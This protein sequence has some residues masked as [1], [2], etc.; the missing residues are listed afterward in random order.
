MKRVMKTALAAAMLLMAGTAS[1]QYKF[2][3][4]MMDH[5]GMMSNDMYTLSQVNFGFGTARSMGMARGL[6]LARRRHRLDRHQP[7]G[8]GY[9]PPQRYLDN[10]HA[11]LPALAK[12]RPRLG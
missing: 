4:L 5:D 2:G 12:Q 8:S 3:G 9:V 6:H 1:A 7:R 11:E 10:T